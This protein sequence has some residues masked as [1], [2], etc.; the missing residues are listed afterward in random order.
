MAVWPI[1]EEVIRESKEVRQAY[2]LMTNDSITASLM[3]R[4]GLTHLATLDSDLQ[5]VPS[6]ALYQPTD[7]P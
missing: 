6:L 2:G 4:H 1:T 5:R 3:T 7:V